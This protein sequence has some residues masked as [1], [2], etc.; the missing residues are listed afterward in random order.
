MLLLTRF[1]HCI[2]CLAG[3]CCFFNSRNES[4]ELFVVQKLGLQ[5]SKIKISNFYAFVFIISPS[6][7][8]R[9]PFNAYTLA[10]KIYQ[11][12]K[13]TSLLAGTKCKQLVL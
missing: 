2:A 3:F 12:L 1:R 4:F 10:L 5:K 6:Q 8:S 13:F 7:R 11:A 9:L